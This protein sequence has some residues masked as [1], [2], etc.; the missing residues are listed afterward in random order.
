M[1]L[2]YYVI[3]GTVTSS[4][5]SPEL[6]PLGEPAALLGEHSS[7]GEVHLVMNAGLWSA[8]MG[9]NPEDPRK[10]VPWPQSSL[11]MTAVQLST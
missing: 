10:Q 1:G 8:A 4:R 2:Q 5:L 11:R 9:R 7:S 6:L 3:K